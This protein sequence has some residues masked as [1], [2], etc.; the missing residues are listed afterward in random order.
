MRLIQFETT[1]GTRHV[2]V[3]E[4]D[5]I[6]VV[7]ATDTTR[8]LALGAIAKGH[9]LVEEVLER[10]TDP[11]PHS[12]RQTLHDGRV[13]PP[14]DHQDPA[15]CLV[16]GTGLTHLGSASTRDKMHQKKA[17]EQAAMTDTVRI[18]QV[19]NRRWTSAG[20][21]AG[22]RSQSGS[23][24]ATARLWY[25]PARPLTSRLLPRMPAKSPS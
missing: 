14:L 12:Y 15:H 25:A 8:E 6:H 24:R 22:G 11:S 7:R 5:E 13:L 10:G 17:G 3:I 9:G 23:T 2:G 19:G 1:Q 20:G 4:G 16:S 18:F 21:H